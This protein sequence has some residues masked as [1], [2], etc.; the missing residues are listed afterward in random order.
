MVTVALSAT[1]VAITLL[2]IL[3]SAAGAHGLHLH[4]NHVV[5][6]SRA[7]HEDAAA[8]AADGSFVRW[9]K[10]SEYSDRVVT[11]APMDASLRPALLSAHLRPAGKTAVFILTN[12]RRAPYGDASMH[13]RS[14]G[15]C[16]CPAD[17]NATGAGNMEPIDNPRDPG[18]PYSRGCMLGGANCHAG[19]L[20]GRETACSA[21][22]KLLQYFGDG[23]YLPDLAFAVRAA[24]REAIPCDVQPTAAFAQRGVEAMCAFDM[25]RVVA[26]PLDLAAA[27]DSAVE[28]ELVRTSPGP[29]VN[30]GPALLYHASAPS[31]AAT[32]TDGGKLP[33]VAACALLSWDGKTNTPEQLESWIAW[34][35]MVGVGR[36]LLYG[37]VEPRQTG[38]SLGKIPSTSFY[39][40][41]E[42]AP[43]TAMDE[44]L[45]KLIAQGDVEYIQVPGRGEAIAFNVVQLAQINDCLSR[46]RDTSTAVKLGDLD[47][48]LHPLNE[49][50]DAREEALKLQESNSAFS[51]LWG[52]RWRRSGASSIFESIRPGALFEADAHDSTPCPAY[53]K[54]LVI[55][56]RVS[57]GRVH[58]DH[59]ALEGFVG[60]GFLP[61]ELAVNHHF[62]G[63]GPVQQLEV[64]DSPKLLEGFRRCV[65]MAKTRPADRKAL[66]LCRTEAQRRFLADFGANAT[67]T[68]REGEPEACF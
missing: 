14:W 6:R 15:E 68:Q 39:A 32:E 13:Y 30:Y 42:D 49:R 29:A 57:F 59:D 21:R 48:F 10:A 2:H 55:P 54:S 61:A 66:D 1:A 23:D 22:G 60:D 12:S 17:W 7:A 44:T 51:S 64:R 62:G 11:L 65:D 37:I 36:F 19:Q 38:G 40:A 8:S 56:E 27:G 24:G 28:L 50:M 34:H 58:T 18:N 33:Q 67:R 4:A 25:V 45:K 3:H 20:P 53:Q 31:R 43:P 5:A 35:R 16:S 46:L 47:E 52:V 41:Q 63:G 9:M 26:C